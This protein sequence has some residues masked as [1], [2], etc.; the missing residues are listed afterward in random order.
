MREPKLHDVVALLLDLPSLRL[1]RGQVGTII[2]DGNSQFALVEF[3]D[4]EGRTYA[5]PTIARKDLLILKLT[6]GC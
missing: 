2:D 5:T 3:A 6:H 4:S 1:L